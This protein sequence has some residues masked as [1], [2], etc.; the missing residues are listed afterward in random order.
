MKAIGAG[1]LA[2]LLVLTACSTPDP[3]AGK[4]P[5]AVGAPEIAQRL[6][7]YLTGMAEQTLESDAQ[8]G[9]ITRGQTTGC[10][11]A[12]VSWGVVPHAER[13]VTAGAKTRKYFEDLEYWLSGAELSEHEDTG[14]MN[15]GQTVSAITG[16]GVRLAAHWDWESPHLTLSATAPCSWP[17]DRPGGPTPGRLP[18]RATAKWPQKAVGAEDT[19]VCLSPKRRVFDPAAPPFAGPGPHP[20]SLIAHPEG[21]DFLYDK[22]RVNQEWIVEGYEE[23]GGVQLVACVRVEPTTDSGRDLTCY[24]SASLASPGGTPY[25][26]DLFEANY[27][28]T[29][30]QA[31]D[32]AVVEQFTLPGTEGSDRNCLMTITDYHKKLALGLDDQALAGKLRPL[33]ESPR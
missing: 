23:Q 14:R 32:G 9:P 3:D 13:T 11:E 16:E 24:Y 33:A 6:D 1:L 7:E 21:T 8:A 29:V 17:S 30:R 19:D 10:T 22:P 25:E 4:T 20:V 2:G 28:V 5:P 15:G 12:D 27:H 31:R 18:P 26:F